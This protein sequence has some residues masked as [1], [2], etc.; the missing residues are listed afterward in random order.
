MHIR[1][2][3]TGVA[4]SISRGIPELDARTAGAFRVVFGVT[5]LGFFWVR[6][7][8]ATRIAAIFDPQIEGDLHATVMAWLTAHPAVADL[9]TPC[10][11]VA[12]AAFTVGVLTR[13]TFLV[14][15]LGAVVWAFPAVAMDSTH[16]HSSLILTL[17]ALIPSRWGDAWSVDAW[18]A[19]IRGTS[20]AAA[21]SGK[22]YGYSV[23]V[24]GLVCGIAFAAAAWAKLHRSGIA[25]IL[26]GTVKYHFIT[27]S[28]NAVVD[29]GLQLAGH[30][31]LAVIASF[32]VIV[33]E[34]FVI[35][36]AFAR[37]EWYRM[38]AGAG[39]LA[40]LVGF[41]LFMGVFW[42]GWWFLLLGFLPWSRVMTMLRRTDLQPS[43]GSVTTYASPTQLAAVVLLFAQQALFST[44]QIER[45][46][47]FT[48]YPMYWNTFANAQAFD[49]TAQTHSRIVVD[50]P[51]GHVELSC[52]AGEDMVEQFEDALAGSQAAAA[53]VW[54]AIYG[55]RPDLR[56]ASAARI[57]QD[58]QLFDWHR[59][60]FTTKRSVKTLGPLAAQ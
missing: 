17:L 55:C 18:W 16:P 40:L 28:P 56:D 5:V 31:W 9:I 54:R 51:E 6:R 39:A 49:A 27:D 50:T 10:L 41:R 30:P 46:P 24:P 36:A 13:V 29:W 45:A 2:I 59:L 34:T 19:R 7:I 44:L 25:W 47:M 15:A 60:V 42:P 8:D 22:Q 35:T 23:W 37:S 33:I 11:L 14:F 4:R 32:G 43:I 53:D 52:N 48:H 1:T 58:V 57:E 26:N 12:G 21:T 20:H 3:A 38:V